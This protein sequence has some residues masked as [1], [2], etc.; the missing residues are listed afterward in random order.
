[1]FGSSQRIAR[2]QEI[3]GE[4]Y[5]REI[6]PTSL[7]ASEVIAQRIVA[8]FHPHSVIDL[9]CGT[10]AMLD[11][12]RLRGVRVKG[13]ELS[14][15]AVAICRRQGLDVE[16]FDLVSESMRP[17]QV[18]ELALSTEVGEHLPCSAADRYVALLCALA[19]VIIFTAATPGQGGLD[20]I[21][22]Q[23]HAYWIEKFARFGCVFQ[24][25]KSLT[26]RKEWR[27]REIPFWYH[28]NLMIFK[29]GDSL[30]SPRMER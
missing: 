15:T 13:F 9:G 10:G 1:M 30:T 18:C 25:E 19:P 27:S 4:H 3:Y 20:H 17:G 21:N 22:E 5:Y 29:R 14:E 23:P 8:E 7:Q 26:W 16:R 28:Q 12:L 24:E 6:G 2:H 11:A